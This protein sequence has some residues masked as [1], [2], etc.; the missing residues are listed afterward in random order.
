MKSTALYLGDRP[1]IPLTIL[2]FGMLGGLLMSGHAAGLTLPFY[3]GATAMWSQVMWQIWT[4]DINN[5][6]NIWT[7]FNSNKYSGGLL[8]AAIIA[9]HF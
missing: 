8:T 6:K 3:C 2:S 7:R 4:A 1:Q 9:G 5:P